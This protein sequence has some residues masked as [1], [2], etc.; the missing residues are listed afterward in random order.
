[1]EV[2][3]PEAAVEIDCHFNPISKSESGS[4]FQ[5]GSLYSGE[6]SQNRAV[7]EARSTPERRGSLY[8]GHTHRH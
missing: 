3:V 7:E 2:D 6:S 5:A 4:D 1:M 8:L